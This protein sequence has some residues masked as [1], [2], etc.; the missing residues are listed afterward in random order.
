[1]KR[2]RKRVD[3]HRQGLKE[4]VVHALSN[5]ALMYYVKTGELTATKIPTDDL[6]AVSLVH[7]TKEDK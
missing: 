1:M 7:Q 5:T 3:A 4:A 2:R 6:Q